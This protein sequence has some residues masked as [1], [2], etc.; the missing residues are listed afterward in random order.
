[1]TDDQA[2][3]WLAVVLCLAV[4]L[5]LLLLAGCHG[6]NSLLNLTPT[7]SYQ[8]RLENETR[9]QFDQKID[10]EVGRLA[11]T[12]NELW[13]WMALLGFGLACVTAVAMT[14]IVRRENDRQLLTLR[15]GVK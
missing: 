12:V 2:E 4:I 13:P 14:W 8:A 6:S 15:N 3:R 11:N 1:M 7:R 10:A 5:L 9:V